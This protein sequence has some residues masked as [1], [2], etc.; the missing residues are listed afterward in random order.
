[1]NNKYKIIISNRN[2]YTE[3]ELPID[4]KTYRIGTPVE[5]DYRLHKDLFFED[6]R[7]DFTNNNGEWSVMCSDNLFISVGD[8][9]RLLTLELQHG[10]II[11]IKYQESNN[12]VLQIEFVVDF[13]SKKKKFER[14]INIADHNKILIGSQNDN[15]IV[16]RSEYISNDKVELHRVEDGLKL[17]VIKASYDVY[18][19]GKKVENGEIIRSGDFFSISDFMFYYKDN[20][21][22]TEVSENCIINKLSYEDKQEKH[23]Y[24]LFV[25]NTRVK[26]KVPD[27]KIDILVPPAPPKKPLQNL[28]LT[29]LPALAMLVLT[30]VVRGFMSQSSNNSF[31]IFSVFSMTMGII[32]SIATYF[33]SKR[34]YKQDCQERI[35]QYYEYINIK[36]EEISQVRDKERDILNANYQDTEADI[37][38]INDFKAELFDRLKE[39]DDFLNVYIGKGSVKAKRRIDYKKAESFETDDVLLD[40]PFEITKQ[41]E[42]IDNCPITLNLRDVN[43]IGVIGEQK[44]NYE[45]LKVMMIDTICRHYYSEVNLYLLIDNAEKYMWAKKVPHLI[46]S[47]GV[48]NVVF[49]IE[50]R[51]NLFETLFKELTQRSS[52]KDCKELPYIVV[53]VQKEWGI[54]T[55][56][57]S[58]FLA[59]ARDLGV[60]F[61]FFETNRNSVPLY[62]DELVELYDEN[63]GELIKTSNGDVKTTF[64][65]PL[66][67]EDTMYDICGKLEP[68]YSEE[69]SL[70]SSLRKSITLFELMN[71]Y[72]VEDIDLNNNWAMSQIWNTMA[73]P[74]GVN[75][76]N[77]IVY[78]DLH[79]KYHGPHGLVAGTTGS[80]KSEVLQ[81]FILSAATIFHPYEISFVIID[82][83]GGGMVNQFKDLPHLVGAITNIDGREIDRS[84]KSIKAELLK[85]QELFAHENVNHI[86]KYI[87][88]YKNGQVSTPLPH[89]VIIVDEF[90]ELK[91]EQPEFMKELIS[92]ARIGRSLGVHLILA[93]QKPSGQVNEQIWSNSKFKLCLKVQNKEDSNEVLKSPLAAEIKEPGRAYLQVGNNEIFELLQSGYSGA[94][95]K[96]SNTNEK[97]FMISQVDFGGKRKVLFRKKK[98]NNRSGN[99]RT[100]LEAIVQYIFDYCEKEHMAKLPNICLAPLADSLSISMSSNDFPGESVPIGVYDDPDS[101]YQ[102]EAKFNFV[103]ENFMIIGSSGTGKTNLLQVIIRQLAT[104]FSPKQA[105]IYILDFGAMYLKN[106]ETLNHVGG[107]VTV[108][109]E[110]KLRNLFKL[111]MEEIQ[112]RKDKFMKAGI[113]SFSSYLESGFNDLPRISI[114]IDNFTAFKEI[115]GEAYEEDFVYITREGLA[116]GINVI[117]TNAQTSGLGYKYMSNFSGKIAFHCNDSSEYS[118]IFDRCRMQPKEIPGR[119]LCRIDKELYEMQTYLAFEGEKEIQRSNAIKKFIQCINE[120][121]INKYA[122]KIPEIPELLD[123]DYIR[124]NFDFQRSKYLYPI[125]LDYATI[126]AVTLDF[127]KTNELC[128]IGNDINQRMKVI[129]SII[130]SV[131]AYLLDESVHIYVIDNIHRQLKYLKEKIYVEA[132]S[133]DYSHIGEII[134]KIEAELKERYHFMMNEEAGGKNPLLLVIINS[135]EAVDYICSNK[136]I[137][138]KYNVIVK[139]YKSLGVSFIYSDMEDS[140]VPYGASELMK[141]FKESK[142]AIITT[143]KLKEFKFCEISSTITRSIKPLGSGDVYLLNGSD[144]DRVKMIEVMKNGSRH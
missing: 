57:L 24:P 36:K 124:S 32:T 20:S 137:L 73:A 50:S 143:Q 69:I 126:D 77:D 127:E 110:E 59:N 4:A 117:I 63:T 82:F 87:K 83:K 7:L 90:A 12:D 15:D 107:V 74:I 142:K 76:K 45:F 81:T 49:D 65:Y 88:L 54:K 141:R 133:I 64:E 39:D 26:Y 2:L 125:A 84:L 60:S 101:Q 100:Q 19:D 116:C 111:L 22:W 55:H 33:S 16:I 112:L 99:S 31:I 113:S 67:S 121:N 13:D 3:V 68:I 102:G 104:I 118:T 138:E 105:N 23:G 6:M 51:N 56:P 85:R 75:A 1:M 130:H 134:T 53:F 86:D 14:I 89:L 70:E 42:Q 40:I 30:I 93:T 78:L 140:P 9:R 80:G 96:S 71:I 52:M 62:C 98:E 106:F 48:R 95:E 25:R 114:I 18:H 97:E 61:V 109:D 21:I 91:A 28:A 132:Y 136:N 44:C 43:A 119:A 27:E 58:K 66:V 41:F 29:L 79:E 5:C 131:E 10:D 35:K 103:G 11:L 123:L 38:I 34:R 72:T 144:V 115:Y 139:Q 92:A 47:Y 129:D 8:T 135:K 94:S 17:S 108:S 120:K 46:N 128:V 122:K 37:N